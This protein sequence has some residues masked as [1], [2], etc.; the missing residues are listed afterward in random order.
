MKWIMYSDFIVK[1]ITLV[2]E[3]FKY[4]CQFRDILRHPNI[5]VT[6]VLPLFELLIQCH[7]MKLNSGIRIEKHAYV[8]VLFLPSSDT[9]TVEVVSK[10]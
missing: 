2:I 6:E 7:I 3:F 1:A 4:H 5:L 9:S 8:V 10:F